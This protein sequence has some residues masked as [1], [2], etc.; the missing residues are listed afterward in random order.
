MSKL[1][2]QLLH[3]HSDIKQFNKNQNNIQTCTSRFIHFLGYA[4]LGS[5]KGRDLR[6]H[7]LSHQ[8]Y[9]LINLVYN[10]SFYKYV[11]LYKRNLYDKYYN[12]NHISIITKI[13]I[14]V[15]KHFI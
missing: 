12:T 14:I 7:P 6:P 11:N 8:I 9:F 1:L 5:R 10:L 13:D 3:F 15:L 4:N 2:I